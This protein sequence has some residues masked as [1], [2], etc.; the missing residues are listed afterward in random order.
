MILLMFLLTYL[1]F[2]MT[3]VLNSQS[4]PLTERASISFK[5]LRGTMLEHKADANKENRSDQ[6]VDLN[7][8]L[9][10]IKPETK[11][12]LAVMRSTRIRKACNYLPENSIKQRKQ[13]FC[14]SE[15]GY[16]SQK[17]VFN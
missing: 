14:E 3:K 2:Y 11:H 9:G 7:A 10:K 12:A 17:V 16:L 6:E 1:R 8:C 15:K 5:N 13:F 4:N